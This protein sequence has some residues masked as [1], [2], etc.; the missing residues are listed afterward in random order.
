MNFDLPVA[1]PFNLIKHGLVVS[2]IADPGEPMFGG[3]FMVAMALAAKNGGAKAIRLSNP[4]D[5][6]AIRGVIDLP[7]IGFYKA[8]MPG[9]SVSVTPTVSHAEMIAAAGADIIELD[10]TQTPHPEGLLVEELVRRVKKATGKPVLADVSTA[11][12]GVLAVNMGADAVMTSI[13]T[14][15]TNSLNDEPDY[16]LVASLAKRLHVPLLAY[17]RINTPERAR[18]AMDT[19]AFAVVV[20]SAITRP[21]VI[22]ERFVRAL[23]GRQP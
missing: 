10:A 7:I 22:T 15:H 14:H 13:A 16:A 11:M 21:Q 6:F 17:G 20:G 19:G 8:H 3:E 18:R 12:E 23:N 1:A 9:Y 5:I 2:C 4:E